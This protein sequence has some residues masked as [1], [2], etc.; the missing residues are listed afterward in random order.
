MEI[1]R[2]F[3]SSRKLIAGAALALAGTTA[4]LACG[5]FFPWALFDNREQTLKAAPNNGFAFEAAHLVAV[6]DAALKPVELDTTAWG[7]DDDNKKA[8]LKQRTD[9][10]AIGLSPEQAALIAR[11]RAAET[12]EAAFALGADLPAAVRLYTAAAVDYGH[13]RWGEAADR[14]KALLD[15]PAADGQLRAT[16]AAYTLG[17]LYAEHQGEVVAQFSR[18]RTLALAGAPDPLGLAVASYGEEAGTHLEQA[19][20]LEPEEKQPFPPDAAAKFHEQM[21]AAVTLYA[22]QAAHG[23]DAGVQ[24]L[25]MVAEEILGSQTLID[26]VIEDDLIRRLLIVYAAA[27][28]DSRIGELVAA[29]EQKH[30]LVAPGADRL[31]AAAYQTAHYDYARRLVD[32]APGP[33]ASWLKAKLALQK[34]DM[35]AAD[36]FYADAIKGFPASPEL[37]PSNEQLVVGE[38]AVLVLSRGEYVEALEQLYP[39]GATYWGDVAY[40][41]E[42]VLTPDELKSFVDT[43]LPVLKVLPER[44]TPLE[45]GVWS[46]DP[47]VSLRNLLARRLVRAG[48]YAEATGY[49]SPP[50]P[51][52]K[53]QTDV[54]PQVDAY[55]AALKR[56][57]DAWRD[58]DRAE[59]WYRA[60]SL[61][62]TAGMEMMG[63]EGPPDQAYSGGV[64]DGGIGPVKL[65]GKFIPDP[66]R[67]RF[68]ASAAAPDRR[69]HY[70]FVAVDQ[71][72]KAADLLPPRS[73]SFAAVLCQATGWMLDSH[74]DLAKVAEIYRRY[75]K[76]GAA[77]PWAANFGTECPQPDFAEA[78]HL[79]WVEPVWTA[80]HVAGRHR[81]MIGG[82]LIVLIGAG[83]GLLLHRRRSRVA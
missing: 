12:G 14:L 9:A 28:T 62:R 47:A 30:I 53:D 49:F 58:V 57:T 80:R 45:H 65:E 56:A 25:R 75:L 8:A 29:I 63:Y 38:R 22:Q 40:L 27:G 24:S 18:V 42:R 5:P 50:D 16:W 11:M 39:V 77:V 60:A 41:A 46:I 54:R 44:Q 13:E 78:K 33:M 64:L 73:Q 19:Q 21:A 3:M 4:A 61:S 55:A 82:V 2:S 79:Q 72:L 69:Y 83:A 52:D 68:A 51:K 43:R 7:S 10:E 26:A 76:Q 48:R 66:E 6:T 71:A 34:G 81:W 67:Q 70:R 1:E 59:A 36:G 35:A 37:S 74:G 17:R 20:A 31:A 23:S 32:K 15:L